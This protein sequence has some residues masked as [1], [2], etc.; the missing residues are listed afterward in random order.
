MKNMSFREASQTIYWW[1]R[2]LDI[3]PGTKKMLVV[4]NENWQKT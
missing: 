3:V 4:A 1:S 2:S